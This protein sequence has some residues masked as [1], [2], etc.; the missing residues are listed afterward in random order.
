V[1]NGG[2]L[3]CKQL[4]I[5]RQVLLLSPQRMAIGPD[6]LVNRGGRVLNRS[7]P[8]AKQPEHQ[9]IRREFSFQEIKKIAGI[10][11]EARRICGKRNGLLRRRKGSRLRAVFEQ[12]VDLA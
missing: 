9:R 6:G 1:R 5:E 11:F 7:S 3:V 12:M 2:G 4:A 10:A 8:S